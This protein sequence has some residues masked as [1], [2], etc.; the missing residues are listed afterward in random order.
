MPL[1]E[2]Q[3]IRFLTKCR[4]FVMK[5][6][7]GCIVVAVIKVPEVPKESKR[8]KPLVMHY[9]SPICSNKKN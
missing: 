2:F 1:K 3:K 7:A 4:I 6:D 5:F 8:K 9:L